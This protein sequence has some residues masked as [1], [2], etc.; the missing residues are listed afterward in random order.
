MCRCVFCVAG[1]ADYSRPGLLNSATGLITTLIN[2]Y[3]AQGGNWSI[4]A[5]ITC[6]ASGLCAVVFLMLYLTY[7]WLLNKVKEREERGGLA[8]WMQNVLQ[9]NNKVRVQSAREHSVIGHE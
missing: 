7:T 3:T 1:L 2:I 8:S 6:V 4:T 5:V 9:Q